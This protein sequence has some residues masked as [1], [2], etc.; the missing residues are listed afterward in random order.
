M[1]CQRYQDYG[2]M[3]WHDMIDSFPPSDFLHNEVEEGEERRAV[4][5]VCHVMRI[6]ISSLA[7]D[8][9]PRPDGFSAS[10]CRIWGKGG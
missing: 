3:G 10:C 6:Y 9:I 2:G 1:E 5:R 8:A 4:V 7:W